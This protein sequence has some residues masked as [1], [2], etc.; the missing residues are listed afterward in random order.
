MSADDKILY[1]IDGHAQIFRAYFAIRGG[2]TSPITG[3][4]TNATFA[5]TGMLMKLLGELKPHYV[6]MAIDMPGKTFRDDIY[7]EYKA[8][9][10]AAPEDLLPQFE[11]IFQI[12]RLFGIPVI[13]QEGAEADDVIAT[14]TEQMVRSERPDD[15]K[16]RVRIVSKDKD[17][18]QLLIRDRVEMF[19]IHTDT[20]ISPDTLKDTR[21]I[22]PEQ[23]VDAL[24]L[25]GDK[26]DNIPGVE[27]IGPK[28]AAK[29]IAEYG[30]I[31]GIYENIDKIKGKRRE[32]LE[33]ARDMM[34]RNIELVRLKRDLEL[35]FELE[36]ARVGGVDANALYA[37]FK[38]L[39]L[40]R[41]E[42]ELDR[43]LRGVQPQQ[44][45]GG[46]NEQ[47]TFA[48]SLFDMGPVPS[49]QGA[50]S[51]GAQNNVYT[52]AS[53]FNYIAIT[54]QSQLN[55]LVAT[56]KQQ[57]LISVDTETLGLGHDAKLCG[58][59]LAWAHRT[60]SESES[61]ADHAAVKGLANVDGVYVPLY[62]PEPERH[63]P[64]ESVIEA[65]RPVLEA[66]SIGKCGHNLKFDLLVLREAGIAM[67]G[68]AFDS[69]IAAALVGAPSQ[70]LDNLAMTI[71]AH[72]MIPISQL[73]GTRD[74]TTPHKTMDQVPLDQITPYAAEDA[75]ITL[76][77]CE[78]L[79]MQL[80]V[81]GMDTLANDVEMPLVEVLADMQHH[82]IQ[83]DAALL[84]EQAVV[85]N[86]RIE[87]LRDEIFGAV[88][89]PFNLDSPKQLAEVLFTELE[90]PVIKKGKTGPSTD[91]EVLQRLADMQ[92]LPQQAAQVP[93]RIVEYRHVTKLVNTYLENLEHSISEKTGRVHAAFH[94]TGA[95]T[96]RLSS[97]GPN[98]QN[99]PIRTNIGREIRRAFVANDGC[100][101]ISA[102]Y[103]QIELRILAHLS[104][105][106]ELVDAFVNNM[107]IHRAVAAQVFE[108]DPA[109]V[110][111]QQRDR[112]KVINFGIIYGI[113]SFGLARRIQG[114]DE[115]GAA[116]LIARYKHRFAG[117]ET[118]M[119]KCVHEAQEHG[120]VTTMCGRRRRIEQITSRTPNTR[121]LG[122]RLA[123]N[124]V[125]QGSAADLIKLA[126][127]NLHRRVL[128]DASE[129]KI[130]IQIHDELVVEAPESN[131]DESAQVVREEMEGAMNL[132]VP[133]KVDVGVGKDWF[134]VK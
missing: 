6:V 11:R 124:S 125:V 45:G 19:D 77:L 119:D 50:A 110:T 49:Q 92:N 74:N 22:T 65:L 7:N 88:G 8:N 75:H 93:K 72:E 83:I 26:V 13:G 58:I 39:G 14:L 51:D 69:M 73:I 89:H 113:T 114:L 85:L 5:F 61:D 29:L 43:L 52:H 116:D 12:T 31:D 59:C 10:E 101:L 4:P 27:G 129:M 97:G 53:D 32:K 107:D 98:L 134:S 95:A 94:Q 68:V 2:M 64:P 34:P 76:R 67:R 33:A 16:V 120:Y 81:M 99:I 47:E 96:G 55:E 23:V 130:L 20:T 86:K 41:H 118:F 112:A 44:A 70:G 106:P 109:D 105:D 82:G 131:S 3:E 40:S 56:L 30:S 36:Q 78:E 133:L 91:F 126:M 80:H 42:A 35:P 17:L 111:P 127:V 48:T 62:S 128:R 122:E 115:R 104:N 121:A 79:K 84:R 38:E 103:S 60:V 54:T 66:A 24:A 108:V 18:E 9:R 102:D 132:N 123:I 1:L 57:P 117:I 87:E 71:L 90:L 46:E 37:L 100:M 21:G 25:M 28:T 15:A 63:L